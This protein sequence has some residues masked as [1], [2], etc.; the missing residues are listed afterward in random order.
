M[1]GNTI[2][3]PI[4][5]PPSTFSG[6]LHQ[7]P[8]E[9]Q[10][11]MGGAVALYV[12]VHGFFEDDPQ[13]GE[14]HQRRDDEFGEGDVVALQFSRCGTF[15]DEFDDPVDQGL[16]DT[17]LMPGDDVGELLALGDDQFEDFA[18]LAVLVE[19]IVECAQKRS[20]LLGGRAGAGVLALDDVGEGCRGVADG[21]FEENFLGLEVHIN[22]ALGD[23]DM[24]GNVLNPCC[25]V[26]V[27]DEFGEGRVQ[28]LRG[29]ELFL[30]GARQFL[31]RLGV[32]QLK[33]R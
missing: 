2:A 29:A 28:D 27:L 32:A 26:P 6:L 24:F 17:L 22:G 30:L 8:V 14:R 4:I 10:I 19:M 15:L 23:A 21:G 31:S 13:N 25:G 1:D 11:E 20:D 3:S 5:D 7:K 18:V 16:E 12:D 33:H 9:K